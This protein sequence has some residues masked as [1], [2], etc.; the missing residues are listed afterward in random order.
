MTESVT[1]F[2][3]KISD[4]EFARENYKK[5]VR[6]ASNL[7]ILKK[8]IAKFGPRNIFVLENCIDSQF[9]AFINESSIPYFKY[10]TISELD[11]LLSKEI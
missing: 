7:V 5:I 10:A 1:I 4:I 8:I 9:L 11:S 6:F 2:S 3:D